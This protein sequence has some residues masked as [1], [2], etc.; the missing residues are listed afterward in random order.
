MLYS[1]GDGSTTQ[2]GVPITVPGIETAV[3]VA[4]AGQNICIVLE[5][6]TMKCWGD[7]YFGQLGDGN[8]GSNVDTTTPVTSKLSNVAFVSIGGEHTCAVTRAG[9]VECVGSNFFGQLGYGTE[10][11]SPYW[12]KPITSGAIQVALRGRKYVRVD[13]ER[14]GLLLGRQRVRRAR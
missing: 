5:D 8:A 2:S 6:G 1:L 14:H 4:V 12:L 3:Q 9:A 10:D 11:Y 7:D 13:G